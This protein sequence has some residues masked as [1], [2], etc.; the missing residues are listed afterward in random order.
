MKNLTQAKARRALRWVHADFEGVPDPRKRGRHA[1]GGLLAL[2]SAAF[3]TG[4]RTLRA[5]ERFGDE[6]GDKAMRGLGLKGAPSDST[7]YWLLAKQ[8]ANGFGLMLVRSVKEALLRKWID[9]D[10]FPHGVITIDGKSVWSGH[11]LAHRSCRKSEKEGVR[12]DY[13][14]LMQRAC[15]V[16]S[17]ARPCVTQTVVPPDAGEADTFGTTF[18]FLMRHFRR[19]FEFVTYDAG[20]TS[21]G[22]AALVH[23]AQKAYVFAI[24][25]NQPRVHLAAISRLGNQ[26]SCD[27]AEQEGEARTQERADG[28]TIRREV[29]RCAVGADDPEIEFAGAKQLWRVR[30]TTERVLP[31][32]TPETTVEDRYFITNRVLKAELALNIVRLHWGIENGPNWTMDLQLGEDDGVPCETGNGIVIASWL[33]VLAYNALSIWR[34]KLKP[35]R[36]E[37]VACWDRARSSLRDALRLNDVARATF[38]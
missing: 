32:G 27:D 16:S 38:A 18:A 34:S 21:R 14:L 12:G 1:H 30:Q 35:V 7:L 5:V 31:G 26:E 4:A 8:K 28:S 36:D 24:K 11:Y 15:L 6:L 10:L 29:F 2:L 25:G 3:A 19:S 22:N 17:S 33:R 13:H 9:N 37:V 23:A 20:G